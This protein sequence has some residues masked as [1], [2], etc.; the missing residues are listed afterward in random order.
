MYNIIPSLLWTALFLIPAFLYCYANVPSKITYIL[1]GASLVTIFLPNSFFDRMQVS[2]T[3]LV[4]RK[5]GV[6]YVNALAQNGSLLVGILKKKYPDYKIVSK[7]NAS[8]KKQ[9]F[10][11]YFFE[12][13]HFS[14]FLFFTLLTVYAGLHGHFYWMLA[15]IIINLFYN[16]YPNLLQQYIRLRLKSVMREGKIS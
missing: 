8:I 9:Y 12:K 14:L 4:Y 15:L 2:K 11:T 1:L 5:M 3:P 10:Q 13:F 16:I 7:T 6:K